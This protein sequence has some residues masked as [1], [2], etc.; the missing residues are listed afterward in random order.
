MQV[1]KTDENRVVCSLLLF[2]LTTGARL[3]EAQMVKWE[4][5][6][7]ERSRVHVRR[8]SRARGRGTKRPKQGKGRFVP[9]E[10]GLADF[11]RDFHAS[12]CRRWTDLSFAAL[13]TGPS[14]GET[15]PSIVQVG[16][17][18]RIRTYDS[19]L[20]RLAPKSRK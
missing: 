8:T 2:L 9:L 20:R 12:E 16:D 14:P 6:D 19:Q 3:N 13:P 18:D 17:P 15:G 5:V 7:L 10:P 4:D 1:L 11:L